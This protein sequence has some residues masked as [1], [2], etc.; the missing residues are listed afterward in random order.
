MNY[1]ILLT[2]QASLIIDHNYVDILKVASISLTL[3]V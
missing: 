1:I 3:Y 2:K